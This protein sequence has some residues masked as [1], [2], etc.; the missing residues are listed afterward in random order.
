LKSKSFTTYR[1]TLYLTDLYQIWQ[2]SKSFHCEHHAVIY[3]KQFWKL[4]TACI[5][6]SHFGHEMA[7]NADLPISCKNF[8]GW[9]PRT[10][11]CDRTQGCIPFPDSRFFGSHNFQ[12]VPAR[13]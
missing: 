3:F 9:H 1:V 12:I 7:Q 13:L 5:F 8:S 6:S 2:K 11:T 10:P 4:A